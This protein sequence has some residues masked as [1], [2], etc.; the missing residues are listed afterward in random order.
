MISFY[1]SN[2]GRVLYP[3]T[4]LDKV[5]LMLACWVLPGSSWQNQFRHDEDGRAIL[6]SL[7]R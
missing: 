5:R 7:K 1:H 3:E 4:F 6:E 2:Y